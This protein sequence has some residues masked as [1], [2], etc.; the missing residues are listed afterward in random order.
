M[1]WR[2]DLAQLGSDHPRVRSYY[3]VLLR[4]MILQFDFFC[5]TVQTVS[6]IRKLQ[7]AWIIP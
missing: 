4:S 6:Q 5:L 1:K 7:A 2:Q 3:P